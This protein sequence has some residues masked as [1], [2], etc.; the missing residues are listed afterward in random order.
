MPKNLNI[1]DKKSCEYKKFT[2]KEHVLEIPDTYIGSIEKVSEEHWIYDE[3]D[4]KIKKKLISYIPGEYKIFDEI[5][6]NSLDQYIRI[7]E[8][9]QTDP[10]L[11]PVKNIKVDIPIV[12]DVTQILDSI[13]NCKINFNR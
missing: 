11:S 3:A 4:N 2:H 1:K 8:R 6:V 10:T 9:Y 13:K 5:I 7:K 12:G